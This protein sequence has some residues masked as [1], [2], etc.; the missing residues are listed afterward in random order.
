[1]NVLSCFD[2][3]S[4]GQLALNRAGISYNNYY[5]SEINK[6]AIKVTTANYPETIQLGDINNWESWNLKDI[7]VI[8]GGS[9]CQG[10]S[11]AGKQLNFEDARSK[12]FF[13][14]VDIINHY[15]PKYFLLENVV[16]KKEYQDVISN[17]L[18]VEPVKI[19][20]ALVSAQNR[21]RLYWA[22]FSIT[23][24]TDKNILL[25]DI[26]EN[27]YVDRD[28]S[29]CIDSNYYKGSNL[30]SYFEKHRRQV[31]AVAMRGR[32][33]VNGKRLD[34]KGSKTTQRIESIYSEKS[35]CLTSVL[36][37]SLIAKESIIRKLT[38]I[39]AER[40]QTLP[41]NYTNGISNTQRYKSIGNGWTV[42][43]I[44][45]ILKGVKQ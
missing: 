29:Y 15:R 39:E 13:K 3:I 19:N 31:V 9:P 41:D 14:F 37:D 42:N 23:Q 26:I 20:S 8:L 24:P 4:C 34:V 43:V 5:A 10:F 12:L 27:G 7:D 11:F 35:N 6:Y 40:L 33:I 44:V 30:K 25:R 28:K 22:N 18:E 38:P 36:K 45:H 21:V 17:L 32:N 16:M 2:G 1:M